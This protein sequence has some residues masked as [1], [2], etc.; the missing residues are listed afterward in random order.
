M[1]TVFR[2]LFYG[3][4]ACTLWLPVSLV[5]QTGTAE[6]EAALRKLQDEYVVA[7]GNHDAAAIAGLWIE[8]GD[9]AGPDGRIVKGRQ[10]I[11]QMHAEMHSGDFAPSTIAL[12]VRAIRWI[13]PDVAV[14]DGEWEIT[15]AKDFFGKALPAM[16]GLYTQVVVK[17]GDRWL[18]ASHRAYVPPPPPPAE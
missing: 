15:G 17:Q 11:E 16:R 3:A 12:K 5:A 9:S 13:K 2:V 8:D 7:W 10:Q 1:K 4:L 14:V 18:A 6:D